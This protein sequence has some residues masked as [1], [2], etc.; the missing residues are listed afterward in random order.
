MIILILAIVF[1]VALWRIG[2]GLLRMA[3]SPEPK[4]PG[5]GYKVI[6]LP[7]CF[8]VLGVVLVSVI[9]IAN[10]SEPGPSGPL[11]EG[12]K[13]IAARGGPLTP[14]DEAAFQIATKYTPKT[15]VQEQQERFDILADANTGMGAEF[16]IRAHEIIKPGMT[17]AQVRKILGVGVQQDISADSVTFVWAYDNGSIRAVFVDGKLSQSEIAQ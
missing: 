9:V 6:P 5:W 1:L 15:P 13:W 14:E 16:G 2:S 17:L 10:L 3:P 8:G 7:V 12:E 11:T 4:A